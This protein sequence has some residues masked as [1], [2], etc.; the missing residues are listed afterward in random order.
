M[1]LFYFLN[2]LCILSGPPFPKVRVSLILE[3]F[4]AKLARL[5]VFPQN[6]SR[7]R[8]LYLEFFGDIRQR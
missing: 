7:R 8:L 4:S 6:H 2:F 5:F 3:V 1:Q